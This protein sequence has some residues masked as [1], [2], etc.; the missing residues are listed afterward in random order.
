LAKSAANAG[1]Q[2][3]PGNETGKSEVAQNRVLK[4]K[5]STTHKF[6]DLL[7]ACGRSGP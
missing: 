2:G 1:R 5:H 6:P 7:P 4:L 3:D